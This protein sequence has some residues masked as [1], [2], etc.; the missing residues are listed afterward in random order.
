V[1]LVINNQIIEQKIFREFFLITQY[2][3]IINRSNRSKKKFIINFIEHI[4]RYKNYTLIM[5]FLNNLS[6][7]IIF[8]L[9]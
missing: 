8:L 2:T 1:S 3:N 9:I 5:L 7:Y 4:Y 6:L